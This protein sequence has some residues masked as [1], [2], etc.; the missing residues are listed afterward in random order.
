MPYGDLR[1]QAVQRF[2]TLE[3]LERERCTIEEREE[4]EPHIRRGGVV[5]AGVDFE[6]ILRRAEEEADVVLWDGGNND[7]PFYRPDVWI[8]VVDPLRPGHEIRYF[9][10]K[11]N[12]E[13]ADVVLFNKMDEAR[14]ADVRAIEDNLARLNPEALVVKADSRIE[15]SDPAA[16]EGKRVL[17]VEDGPTLTHGGMT[18]GAATVAATRFGAAELVDPRPFL[19]GT[20][21]ETFETYPGIGPL[22][23]AMGYGDQQIRDLEATIDAT[24]CD[25]VVIGTPIDLGAIIAIHKPAVRVGYELEERPEGASLSDVLMERLGG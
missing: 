12:F 3:D 11:E 15:V 1:A 19:Q 24:Q 18:R 10:G 25:V 6:R 13:R 21:K 9:P 4:Y 2:G 17:C 23:P 8:C 20:L 22:L 5:F 16:I 14:A 7:T